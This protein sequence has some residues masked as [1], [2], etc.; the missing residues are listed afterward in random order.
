MGAW[1]TD[2]KSHVAH[3]SG[4]DFY[5]S[6]QAAV[7]DAAGSAAHRADRTRSGKT[8]VLKDVGEGGRRATW[9]PRRR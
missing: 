7:I 6:E 4:G 1:S 8:T 2:S 5:G 3:M 9:S